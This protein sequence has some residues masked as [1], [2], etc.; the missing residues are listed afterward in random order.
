MRYYALMTKALSERMA[1]DDLKRKGFQ[2][3]FAPLLVGRRRARTS[4]RMIETVQPFFRSYVFVGLQEGTSTGFDPFRWRDA[5]RVNGALRFVRFADSPSPMPIGFVEAMQ[6]AMDS[7]G[8][9]HAPDTKAALD[10]IRAR[11]EAMQAVRVLITDGPFA[12]FEG[13]IEAASCAREAL[14]KLAMLD[15]RHRVSILASIF[16]RITSVELERHQVEFI[17][18]SPSK[19]R[20]TVAPEH[21]RPAARPPRSVADHADAIVDSM[22]RAERAD[23]LATVKP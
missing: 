7:N 14:A 23:T 22:G 21:K 10:P 11:I 8:L 2:H 6:G 13:E 3:V 12:S 1:V 20:S 5:E 18:D 15:T 19:A 4:N 16:G 9:I 17:D